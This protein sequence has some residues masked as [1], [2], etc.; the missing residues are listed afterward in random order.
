VANAATLTTLIESQVGVVW[1]DNERIE[2]RA[3]EGN[4]LR[5]CTRGTLGTSATT[6]ASG[7]TVTD[8]SWVYKIPTLEHFIDYGNDLGFAY[9]DTGISLSATGTTPMHI[10]IRNAGSG[11]L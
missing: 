11:T 7:A 4:T 5:Y 8:A 9:N 2:Y 3:I 1:I 6:H 10:F